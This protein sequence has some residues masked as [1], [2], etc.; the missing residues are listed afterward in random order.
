[1]EYKCRQEIKE[2]SVFGSEVRSHLMREATVR[3]GLPRREIPGRACQWSII[4]SLH[5]LRLGATLH[6]NDL[7]GSAKEKQTLN[8]PYSKSNK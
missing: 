6:F 3:R 8:S 2:S 7:L 1:M 5:K 4:N